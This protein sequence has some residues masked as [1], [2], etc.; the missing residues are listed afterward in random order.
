MLGLG[1]W[2]CGWGWVGVWVAKNWWFVGAVDECESWHILVIDKCII[3]Y[4]YLYKFTTAKNPKA[5]MTYNSVEN[6]L[7]CRVRVFIE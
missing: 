3:C 7:I 5:S 2:S 1:A 4:I 6:Y